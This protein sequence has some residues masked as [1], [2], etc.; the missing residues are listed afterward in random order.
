MA[1]DSLNIDS[2]RV[3]SSEVNST[4][5]NSKNGDSAKINPLCITSRE[6]NSLGVDTTGICSPHGDAKIVIFCIC[7]GTFN[8]EIG[9]HIGVATEGANSIG[10]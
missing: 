2:C 7:I 6:V 4:C 3:D 10:A 5:V 9:E 8:H 1:V